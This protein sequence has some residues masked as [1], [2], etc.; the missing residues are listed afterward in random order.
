MKENR[1]CVIC[2]NK[3]RTK[4]TSKRKTCC[5][6]CSRKYKDS[7]KVKQRKEEYHRE[8][9]TRPEVRERRLLQRSLRL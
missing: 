8:Y 4:T 5:A 7:P 3:F 1:D 6:V 2:P 9:V